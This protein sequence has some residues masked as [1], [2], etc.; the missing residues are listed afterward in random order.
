MNYHLNLSQ[1]RESGFPRF[2]QFFKTNI[3]IEIEYP[4]LIEMSK[5]ELKGQCM[6]A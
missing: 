6:G 2:Q 4:I 5:W 3:K 1:V